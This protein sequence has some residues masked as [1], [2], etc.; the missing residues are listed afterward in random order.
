MQCIRVLTGMWG[1][2]GTTMVPRVKLQVVH[3]LDLDLDQFQ[4]K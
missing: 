3:H 4:K 2:G 1:E